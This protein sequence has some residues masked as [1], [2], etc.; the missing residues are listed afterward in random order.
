MTV[1]DFYP[2]KHYAVYI[3]QRSYGDVS[4]KDLFNCGIEITSN[5]VTIYHVGTN[6]IMLKTNNYCLVYHHD[7]PESDL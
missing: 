7:E 6:K 2:Y 1:I 4:R 3:V 5:Y